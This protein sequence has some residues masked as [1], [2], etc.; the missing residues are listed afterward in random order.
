M[1]EF[2]YLMAGE[3]ILLLAILLGPALIIG[4]AIQCFML[5]RAGLLGAPHRLFSG[6]T[7]LASACLAGLMTIAIWLQFPELAPDALD[8][9]SSTRYFFIPAFLS[10]AIVF[11]FVTMFVLRTRNP[12]RKKNQ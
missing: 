7:L 11:P 5:S 10:A 9:K 6:I 8:P 12:R 3:T 2:Q 1:T 4:T